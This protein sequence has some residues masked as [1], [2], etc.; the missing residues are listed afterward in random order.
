MFLDGQTESDER[1]GWAQQLAL[2]TQDV[3][4][5]VN[6]I[7]VQRAISWDLTPTWRELARLARSTLRRRL[8]AAL[9]VDIA[10]H[11]LALTM[12]LIGIY[13][14]Q[15]RAGLTRL[16][17]TVLAGT[18]LVGIVPGLAFRD[19]AETSSGRHPVED[20]QPVSDRRLDSTGRVSGDRAEPDHAHNHFDDAGWQPRPDPEFTDVQEHHHELLGQRQQA[21]RVARRHRLRQF[22]REGAGAD[23]INLAL[24]VWGHVIASPTPYP[25]GALP[26]P[27]PIRSMTPMTEMARSIMTQ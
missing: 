2:R 19:I 11:A 12:I 9:L 6:R 8:A 15:Q 17:V 26:A 16:A 13:L 7:E 22:D 21:G 3:V 24:W 1:W 5:V 14:V 25:A 23:G 27:A 18:G 20:T 4:A 10:A